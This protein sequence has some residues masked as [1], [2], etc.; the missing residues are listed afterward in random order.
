MLRVDAQMLNRGVCGGLRAGE[1]LCRAFVDRRECCGKAHRLCFISLELSKEVRIVPGKKRTPRE[2]MLWLGTQAAR[3]SVRSAAAAVELAL[4]PVG[5]AA[6]RLTLRARAARPPALLGQVDARPARLGL[7]RARV[8][9][10]DSASPR[11]RGTL[12]LAQGP[13]PTSN[14]RNGDQALLVRCLRAGETSDLGEVTMERLLERRGPRE[15]VLNCQKSPSR[16]HAKRLRYEE[17]TKGKSRTCAL[18]VGLPR[19]RAAAVLR[20]PVRRP[21]KVSI[22]NSVGV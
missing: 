1:T 15:Y 14:D 9:D 13:G 2:K 5:R 3:G 16:P 10:G 11:A 4:Q 18:G 8:A 19:L 20:G 7:R 17:R 22:E 12:L 6:R 21:T